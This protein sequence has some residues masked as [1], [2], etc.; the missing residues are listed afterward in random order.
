MRTK[1]LSVIFVEN[2]PELH[3]P[4]EAFLTA[5]NI[6][7][8]GRFR[9]ADR[10][11]SRVKG[12]APDFAIVDLWLTEMSGYELIRLLKRR[13]PKMKIIAASGERLA[14]TAIH[15]GADAFIL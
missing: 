15:A 3:D 5:E 10:A 4:L 9:N 12:I 8:A 1:P 7:V 6:S 13:S 14:R 2:S 11:L